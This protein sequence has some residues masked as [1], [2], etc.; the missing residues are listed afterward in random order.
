MVSCSYN[1]IVCVWDI[2]SYTEIV[3]IRIL[4]HQSRLRGVAFDR[5]HPNQFSN[6]CKH[7]V[8]CFTSHF[9]HLLFSCTS[10]SLVNRNESIVFGR[11]MRIRS[12]PNCFSKESFFQLEF[13]LWLSKDLK[14]QKFQPKLPGMR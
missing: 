10:F 9:Q 1:G 3:L 8:V 13:F 14:F 6:L 11:I 12:F 7:P 4:D 5:D 2:V